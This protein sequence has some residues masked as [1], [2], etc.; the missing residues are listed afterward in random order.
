MPNFL[1]HINKKHKDLQVRKNLSANKSFVSEFERRYGICHIKSIRLL[2]YFQQ[3]ISC[4]CHVN[5]NHY[6]DPVVALYEKKIKND[7]TKM[8]TDMYQT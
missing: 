3:H 8:F 2:V 5:V 7:E 4:Q 6:F 1:Q